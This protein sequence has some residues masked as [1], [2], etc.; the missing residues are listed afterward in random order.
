MYT[1]PLTVN[2]L[3]R[4]LLVS[5]DDLADPDYTDSEFDGKD[6]SNVDGV[7]VPV[8]IDTDLDTTPLP[9]ATISSDEPVKCTQTP[10]KCAFY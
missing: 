9:S 3:E 10:S 1:P 4:I 2:E 6:D 8:E 5:D 7:D